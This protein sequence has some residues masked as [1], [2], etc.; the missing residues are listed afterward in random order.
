MYIDLLCVCVCV[1]LCLCMFLWVF[2]CLCVSC[3]CLCVS[4]IVFA[5]QALGLFLR[6]IWI[7]RKVQSPRE[8]STGRGRCVSLLR[9]LMQVL[10]RLANIG[11][12]MEEL[13]R[14]TFHAIPIFNI[15][16]P[17]V[18]SQCKGAYKY[19]FY[20]LDVNTNLCRTVTAWSMW[21]NSWRSC[22]RPSNIESSQET[23]P[24]QQCEA[25]WKQEETTRGN[26]KRTHGDVALNRWWCNISK[27]SN[28]ADQ[29]KSNIKLAQAWL[30]PV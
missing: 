5:F 7:R 1:Y 15:L 4:L 17:T 26:K 6:K 14:Q 30:I 24:Q 19:L 16:F 22:G 20:S 8:N 3:V 11:L 21:T 29:R 10:Q 23:P 28:Q 2:V 27:E 12:Y 13:D 25:Q 9:V 18:W